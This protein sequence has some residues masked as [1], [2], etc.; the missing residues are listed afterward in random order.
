ME[1][2]GISI[3]MPC[4]SATELFR[5]TLAALAY[6]G[7][8]AFRGAPDHFSDFR[9]GDGGRTAGEILAHICDVLD[10]GLIMAKDKHVWHESLPRAWDL[11]VERFFHALGAFDDFMASGAPLQAPLDRLFQGPIADA[12][13]HVGQIAML[14]RLADAPVK[15][16]NFFKAHIAIGHIE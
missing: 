16:E 11:D 3:T 14:R 9:V 8:K 13:T 7:G 15:G 4:E 1:D 12:L 6:R 5:H 2:C 10:W